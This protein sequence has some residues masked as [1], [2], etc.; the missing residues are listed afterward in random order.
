MALAPRLK[1]RVLAFLTS[2]R[3]PNA[4]ATGIHRAVL[5]TVYGGDIAA[6]LARIYA[7]PERD[8]PN[9]SLVVALRGRKPAFVRCTFADNGS[10]LLCE[11]VPGEY[12][13]KPNAPSPAISTAME[14]RLR[15]AG[16]WRDESG[17]AVSALDIRADSSDWGGAAVTILAPLIDVF[18]AD[19][20][21]KIDIVAPLAPERDEA[22]IRRM[23]AGQS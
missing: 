7:H 1:A 15:K 23:M 2:R 10:T 6:R 19:P 20:G 13:P 12:P 5:Y 11:A 18:G 16:Y 3:L 17:R 9:G 8:G 4:D 22:A 14:E 21:S